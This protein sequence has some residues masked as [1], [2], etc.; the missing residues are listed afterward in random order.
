MLRRLPLSNLWRIL[1]ETN[2][3]AIRRGAESRFEVLVAGD[4][5]SGAEQLARMIGDT[6]EAGAAPGDGSRSHPWLHVTDAS[7]PPVLSLEPFSLAV[8]VSWR[9]ELSPALSAIRDDL[10]A[11]G[12]PIVVVIIG[13]PARLPR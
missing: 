10:A 3:E 8:L 12:V 6:G 13:V 11:L 4:D 1:R 2:L 5:R 7:T 9:A